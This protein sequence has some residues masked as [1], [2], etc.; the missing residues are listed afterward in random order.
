MGAPGIVAGAT[1]GAAAAAFGSGVTLCIGARFAG[2]GG[3]TSTGAGGGGAVS[4]GA[5]GSVVAT[6]PGSGGLPASQRSNSAGVTVRRD[7][8]ADAGGGCGPAGS[9]NC[10]SAL[11]AVHKSNPA[12]IAT[13][14]RARRPP[15]RLRRAR[16]GVFRWVI[17]N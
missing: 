2:G 9:S 13:G 10:A 5:R 7:R 16:S 1:V 8:G 17:G 6:S 14:I 15:G 12:A 3:V 11:A 4:S